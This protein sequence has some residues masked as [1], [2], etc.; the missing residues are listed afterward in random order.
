MAFR[1]FNP[2]EWANEIDSGL[3]FRKKFGIESVWGE[4]E[5][6]Y[7]NVHKSMANDG[8][9]IIM[10]QVD[11]LLSSLTVPNPAVTVKPENP[12]AVS[13]TPLVETLDN[14][15]LRELGIQDEVDTAE[16]HAALFG[17]GICKI[18]FDSEYGY[19]PNM[20]IG[21]PLK[22]GFTLTQ[23]GKKGD[24]RIE[25]D[26]GVAPGMPWV[27]AVDP[28][29]VVVP[30]GT[31]RLTN[32]PWIAHR[33][34]R[35]IDDLKADPKYQ[36]TSRL[37]PT[38]SMEDFVDTYRS[39]VRLWQPSSSTIA[40]GGRSSRRFTHTKRGSREVEFIEL[41]EIHDKRTKEILVIA[42]GH[43][44][45]LRQE[46][47]ALQIDNKLP[48]ASISFTPKSRSF[49]TTSDAYYLQAIQMEIS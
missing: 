24:R 37:E 49:W 17:C 1:Q 23:I 5:A 39:T 40:R 20:D 31:H 6:M 41:Y 33:F 38:L 44:S 14:V 30:W 10:S 12:D 29:D 16:L 42:P 45:F 47:N 22:I 25:H 18:G 15:L 46:I 35:Q 43:P 3:D 28:R 7:Y 48:F 36:N 26:S 2:D 9:N 21:G 8:P 19:A 11:A 34:V 13:R 4:L 32:C 27:K